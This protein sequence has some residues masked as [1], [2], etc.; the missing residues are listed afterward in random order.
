MPWNDQSNGGGSDGP[1]GGRSGG[2]WGQKPGGP[3]GQR[4][5]GP[6]GPGGQQP[7]D[8]EDVIRQAQASLNRI[9]GGKG[10]GGGGGKGW[11]AVSLL[12]VLAV[13]LVLWFAWPGSGWYIVQPNEQAVVLRFGKYQG[14]TANG[15]HLKLPPPIERVLIEEVTTVRSV[16]VGFRSDGGRGDRTRNVDGES[17]MLT[18]DANIVDIDFTVN[19]VVFD[20]RDF[21]FNVRNPEETVKAVAESAMREVIGGRNLEQII[22]TE[23][24][25]VAEATGSL[26]QTTLDEYGAGISVREVQLQKADPPAR[27][28][29]AFRDVENAKQEAQTTVNQATAFRNRIVPEARGRAAAILQ[30]AQAYRDQVVAEARG[31]AERFNLIYEQYALAP[32]VTRQRMFLETLEKVLGRS[33]KVL[34]DGEGE[35]G[36][37]VVPYLPLNELQRNAAPARNQQGAG[38]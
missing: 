33:N 31:E 24:L 32:E 29:D 26:M 2:P 20:L 4:P 5:G 1:W 7:P 38:Q 9:F 3:W 17:L 10:S 34:I 23:R 15:F 13:L 8:L 30:E 21:L 16:E 35:G 14:T 28:I 36:P 22:T 27:V 6:G 37:G 19:W 11:S 12:V 25:Q 18:G